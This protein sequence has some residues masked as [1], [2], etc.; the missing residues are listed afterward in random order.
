[1]INTT[2]DNAAAL[3]PPL[4]YREW[5]QTYRH[6]HLLTQIVGKVRLA[7]TPWVNHSWHVPFYVSPRGLTTGAIPYGTRFFELTFD[8]LR[9]RL[10]IEASDGTEKAIPLGPGSV[11]GFHQVFFEALGDLNV[12]VKI[13]PMP[14]EIADAVP[15]TEDH[16]ARPYDQQAV[17]RF[18]R[19]LQ[20]ASRIFELFRTRFIGKNSPVHF[21]WG[22][23]DLAVTRFSGR[24]A[25]PSWRHSQSSRRG[26]ARGLLAR[27][28][29]R[30][31]LARGPRSRISGLLLLCL[32][33]TGRFC[34]CESFA[35]RGL[36]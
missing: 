14:N 21:F 20:Q 2:A 9:H 13:F 31:L 36:L 4:P 23:F 27:G 10:L 19:T 28:Q 1:M 3:W 17:L 32:S 34:G 15:F 16:E 22:S 6:L 11:A 18:W 8:F 30:W 35:A 29:Q 26:H 7:L 25:P 5:Q 33:G 12:E 24:P